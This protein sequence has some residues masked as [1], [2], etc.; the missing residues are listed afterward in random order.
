MEG[1]EKE[2]VV[3]G[4]RRDGGVGFELIPSDKWTRSVES[5]T[6]SSVIYVNGAADLYVRPFF[7]EE[8]NDLSY[9]K[10]LDNQASGN[11]SIEKWVRIQQVPHAAVSVAAFGAPPATL[12][13]RPYYVQQSEGNSYG[14]TIIPW[15]PEGPYKEQGP[16]L[17]AFRI[18]VVNGPRA[19]TVEARGQSGALLAGSARHVRVVEPL[20]QPALLGALALVPLVALVVVLTARRRSYSAGRRE[21]G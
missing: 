15:D 6:P 14:Y 11:P 20:R 16:N 12:A 7:E 13:E 2:L 17:I 1:S 8:Y 10:T 5:L 9:Q 4:P 19:F 21:D 3:D 18:P